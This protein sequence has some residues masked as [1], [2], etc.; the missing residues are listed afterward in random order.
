MGTFS[1]WS[2]TS[3]TTEGPGRKQGPRVDGQSRSSTEDES[4]RPRSAR[5]T[6]LRSP[7]SGSVLPRSRVEVHL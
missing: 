4:G 1:S 3:D 5:P 7:E 2:G 6:T